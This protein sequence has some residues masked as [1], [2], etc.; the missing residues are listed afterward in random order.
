MKMQA[1]L[2][3]EPGRPLEVADLDLEGPKGDL[4]SKAPTKPLTP[5][6]LEKS[7]EA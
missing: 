4:I 5:W 7:R 3:Y 2:L 1:S 6:R